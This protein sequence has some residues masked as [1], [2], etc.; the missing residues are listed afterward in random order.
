MLKSS[1]EATIRALNLRRQ[2]DD[3][4]VW[5]DVSIEFSASDNHYAD[6]GADVVALVDSAKVSD[7]RGV[8]FTEVKLGLEADGLRLVASTP[9]GGSAV[10]AS[11]VKAKK[12]SLVRD[13]DSPS[14]PLI[15]ALLTIPPL[16]RSQRNYLIENIG[17][18]VT[19]SLSYTQAEMFSDRKAPERR[20][21]RPV[22]VTFELHQGTCEGCGKE[23]QIGEGGRCLACVTDIV[24]Q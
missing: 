4:G 18:V 21:P 19:L 11:G 6:L 24:N 1:V 23:T 10:E 2:K 8:P 15:R 22:S 17:Q 7:T 3:P 14:R 12:W 5:V 20:D 9:S 13:D 16:E